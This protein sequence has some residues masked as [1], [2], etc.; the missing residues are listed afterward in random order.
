MLQFRALCHIISNAEPSFSARA[1][2][3]DASVWFFGAVFVKKRLFFLLLSV[4]FL[5]IFPL[6]CEPDVET[7]PPAV[8]EIRLDN[9]LRTE[10]TACDELDFEGAIVVATYDDGSMERV[11]MTREMI[12]DLSFDM[13]RPGRQSVRVAYGGKETTFGIVV[14]EWKKEG[15]ALCSEPYVTDYVVGQKI[16]TAG[17]RV[18]YAYEGEREM[19]RDVKHEDLKPYDNSEPGERTIGINIFDA[20]LSFKARFAPKTPLEIA[21]VDPPTDNFVFVGQAEKFDKSGMTVRIKYDNDENPLY[22]LKDPRDRDAEFDSNPHGDERTGETI[23][24]IDANDFFVSVDDSG[25][26]PTE[27]VMMYCPK[28]YLEK[29]EYAYRFRGVAKVR[30]GDIVRAW[31]EIGENTAEGPDGDVRL[32]PVLSKCFGTISSA[33]ADPNDPKYSIV[34]AAPRISYRYNDA[35]SLSVAPGETISDNA[36][37]GKLDGKAVYSIGGGRVESIDRFSGE[38]FVRTAPT[39]RF[40]SNVKA[41]SFVRLVMLEK[42]RP[43]KF[44]GTTI[45]NMIEDDRLN[46]DKGLVRAYFDD[47]STEDIRMSDARIN[48]VNYANDSVNDP[49]VLIPGKNP[50]LVTYGGV[51][52]VGGAREAKTDYLFVVTMES[53]YPVELL[54]D[55]SN[56][57]ISGKTFYCGDAIPIGSMRYRLKFNNGKFSDFAPI[58]NDMVEDRDLLCEKPRDWN[59]TPF[60]KTVRFRLTDAQRETVPL[61]I[62]DDPKLNPS[63]NCTVAPQ[64]IVGLEFLVPPTKVYCSLGEEISYDGATLGVRYANRTLEKID[65]SSE[66]LPVETINV[67]SWDEIDGS[68]SDARSKIFVFKRNADTDEIPLKDIVRKLKPGYEARVVYADE[69]GETGECGAEAGA[70]AR[71][72]AAFR[73]FVIPP[74]N[75]VESI[76][77]INREDSSG[78][79]IAKTSYKEFEDWDLTGLAM[80]VTYSTGERKVMD[81][82]DP[83]MIVKGDTNVVG[84][85]IPI[86]FGYLGAVDATSF[87]I[88]VEPRKPLRIRLIKKGADSYVSGFKSRIDFSGYE[89]AVEYNA[90]PDA[91]A[92][93]ERL[94][95][96]A[97]ADRMTEGFW[98]K[99]YFLS[100][101]A[102]IVAEKDRITSLSRS[103]RIAYELHYS[104]KLTDGTFADASTPSVADIVGG[105]VESPEDYVVYVRERS[106]VDV[107][108]IRYEQDAEVATPDGVEIL[109]ATHNKILLSEDSPI[110]PRFPTGPRGLPVLTEAAAGWPIMLGGFEKG[111]ATERMLR[112]AYTDNAVDYV[113]IDAKMLDYKVEDKTLGYRPVT[114]TYRNKTCKALIYVWDASLRKIEIATA[115]RQNYIF[116]AISDERGLDLSAGSIRL[117]FDTRN[118]DGTP[119]MPMHKYMPMANNPDLSFSGFV[120]GL[121]SEA[122]EKIDIR[123]QYKDYSSDDM[124]ATF[125]IRA[126]DRQDVRFRFSNI[127]FF[128]GNAAPS[129]YAVEPG[130]PGFRD[131]SDADISLGY[132]ESRNLVPLSEYLDLSASEQK[133]YVAVSVYDEDKKLANAMF[134]K[135]SDIV[136]K[137]FFDLPVTEKYYAKKGRVRLLPDAQIGLFDAEER[138]GFREF[139]TYCRAAGGAGTRPVGKFWLLP[140]DSDCGDRERRIRD[141]SGVEI[142]KITVEEYAALS[143]AEKFE[144][145][146]M[147]NDY[148]ILMSVVDLNEDGGADGREY[149]SASYAL[150]KYTIIRKVIDLTVDSR[151]ENS[152]TL[153]V[154][155]STNR[156]ADTGNPY[157][158]FYLQDTDRNAIGSAL[159][160]LKRETPDNAADFISNAYVAS[161]NERYFELVMR[162]DKPAAG[163][164]PEEKTIA[165]EAYYAILSELFSDRFASELRDAPNFDDGVFP[166]LSGLDLIEFGEFEP[167]EGGRFETS[168]DRKEAML[169]AIS[170]HL[171]CGVNMF[172]SSD[173]PGFLLDDGTC[174]PVITYVIPFGSMKTVKKELQ[175]LSGSLRFAPDGVGGYKVERGTLGHRSY[176]INLICPPGLVLSA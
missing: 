12:D 173:I 121:Y 33:I 153:R 34:T 139:P 101:S 69:Y 68:L 19:V 50:V 94:R 162:F 79:P 8:A 1:R 41:K 22:S 119:N 104:Q 167:A 120:K 130:I 39:V 51:V 154:T 80:E 155:A 40:K 110:P 56:N 91:V 31:D 5:T 4:A 20:E 86:A 18:R 96:V 77:V 95:K 27:P 171:K 99:M 122:G 105:R 55:E 35:E 58:L 17:A 126:Y 72:T 64:P 46:L 141:C 59:G 28:E 132:V 61:D 115:P 83:E 140:N 149:K 93:G 138:A 127:I 9:I 109:N 76:K 82:L 87:A 135:N 24:D 108:E 160:A 14:K 25:A 97:S 156:G 164:T 45:D 85:N 30:K 146:E 131:P 168:S 144:Y 123:V 44:A 114:I 142:E 148:Y 49:F 106:D 6:G 143:D 152:A 116:D 73:Y 47:G 67:Q 89:F 147:P 117:V 124:C 52:R 54:I 172:D 133:E 13:N 137:N 81:E 38:I 128:Y 107:R 10:Y 102:S 78:R 74:G 48:L 65:M 26:G 90:G 84:R 98:H 60:A 134:V 118:Y 159:S 157:A 103:G 161:Q 3:S 169:D 42:P 21:L 32:G 29:D 36:Y 7:A 145:E 175:L 136:S 63:L 11:E 37:L 71:A 15:I 170:S 174:K 66:D 165:A 16:D 70:R 92:S 150:Q 88:D 111:K 113:P 62:R 100:A 112:V 151:A 57:A 163:L 166:G 129:G 2:A 158:V 43:I 176:T 53:K 125:Q 75:K 23:R